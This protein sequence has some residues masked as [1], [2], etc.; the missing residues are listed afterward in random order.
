MVGS[1]PSASTTTLLQ[2]ARVKC[3]EGHCLIVRA[4]ISLD[5]RKIV[6]LHNSQLVIVCEEVTLDNGDV[7]ARLVKDSDPRGVGF[8]PLGWVTSVKNGETKLAM[9]TATEQAPARALSMLSEPWRE[10]AMRWAAAGKASARGLVPAWYSLAP[11][12]SM[13][14]W[15]QV[16]VWQWLGPNHF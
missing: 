7:R 12:R 15:R 6:D 9:L 1:A 3:D 4:A 5:S 2:R 16:M 8:H 14:R 10:S 13:I 11:A